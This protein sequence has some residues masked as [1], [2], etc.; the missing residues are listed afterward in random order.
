[1]CGRTEGAQHGPSPFGYG[2]VCVACQREWERKYG[3]FP[4]EVQGNP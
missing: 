3:G 2:S 1:M 4:L